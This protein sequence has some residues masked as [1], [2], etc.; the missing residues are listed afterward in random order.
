MA[1]LCPDYNEE[2]EVESYIKKSVNAL[3]TLK[4]IALVIG[5]A[6]YIDVN[7]EKAITDAK[8]VAQ[9]LASM[10]FKVMTGLNLRT[11]EFDLAVKQFFDSAK[12]CDIVFFFYTGYGYQSDYLLPIDTKIDDEG[13][14]KKWFSLNFLLNEFPKNFNSKK[15]F[16]LDIDRSSKKGIV[17]A[18]MSYRNSL[19]VFSAA[20]NNAAFNGVGRNSLFTEQFLKFLTMKNTSFQEIFRLTR[21]ATMRVSKE[22]QV[23]TIYDN[24]QNNLYLNW[25][26]E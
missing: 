8:D 19:V 11:S 25:K 16:V 5:N 13:N 26:I 10:N 2:A 20:P 1:K 21:E 15:I 24:I 17:P 14:L 9:A 23:P 22:R 7:M 18:V 3:D 6:N 4:K 12:N